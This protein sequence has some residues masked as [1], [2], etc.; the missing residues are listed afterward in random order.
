M[1]DRACCL[2]NRPPS[3]TE[4]VLFQAPLLTIKSLDEAVTFH[5]FTQIGV[6]VS[7]SQAI[8]GTVVGVGIVGGFRTID[9]KMLV[10]ITGGWVMP[11]F[12]AGLMTLLFIDN[13]Y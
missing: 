1:W 6:P 11:P 3:S 9:T 4:S 10:K 7:S 2:I 5:L 13:A 8:V 12:A